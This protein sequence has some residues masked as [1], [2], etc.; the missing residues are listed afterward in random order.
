MFL[1]IMYLAKSPLGEAFELVYKLFIF[2]LSKPICQLSL[3]DDLM[4]DGG[5]VTIISN[6]ARF[7]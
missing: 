2:A 3:C 7:C 5:D 1:S 4:M 6:P